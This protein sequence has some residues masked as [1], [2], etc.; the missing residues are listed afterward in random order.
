MK[1]CEA[2]Q[3][4]A[5]QIH[6]PAQELHTIPL[7]W[8]FVVWGMDILEPFPRALGGY[9][10][11]FIAIDKFIK[12][13]EVE[14]VRGIP[15]GAAVK[16]IK[17]LVCCFGVPNRIITDNGMQFTSGVFKAYCANLGTQIC[18]A[19]VAHPRSNGQAERANA[20]VLKGLKTKTFNRLKAS[21]TSWIEE[22]NP[23]QI[24]RASCRE[25]V[26]VLV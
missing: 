26:Y 19:S 11:L 9:R 5:K 23:V 10:F 21:G 25:R 16:F 1:T 20:E 15:V 18:Y 24:G 17:G 12:W 2:C 22:L 14:P 7:S 8:P 3:F 6:Q 4:H 13:H